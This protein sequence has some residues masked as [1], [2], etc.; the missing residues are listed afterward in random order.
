MQL[1]TSLLLLLTLLIFG[2][3]QLPLQKRFL[4]KED[5][6]FVESPDVVKSGPPRRSVCRDYLSY[7]PDTNHLDHS[8]IRYVRVNVHFMNHTDSTQ[9]FR[10]KDVDDFAKKLLKAAQYDLTKDKKPWLP[11]SIDLPALPKQYRYVLTPLPGDPNDTGVYCHYDDDLYYFVSSGRNRN[12]YSM[13]V[14]DK[15][16]IQSDSVLNIFIMP[17]HPDSMKSEKYRPVGGGIALRNNL[18]LAG[19]YESGNHSPWA[20]RG[21]LNH[22]IGHVLGLNH[23]WGHD[24][25]DDTPR[26]PNCWNRSEKP[27]CDTMASNNVMDY[28]AHQNAWTPCQIGK[29]HYNFARLKSRQRR[30]LIANWCVLKEENTIRIKEQIDWAGARDI[31]GHLIIEKGGVLQIRC[32]LSLPKGAKI[33]IRPGGKLILSNAH[34]HNSCGDEWEGIEIQSNKKGK[35]EVDL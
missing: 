21:L 20:F 17:H 22:E 29:I 5:I 23:A 35:G 16:A 27:P 3:C 26:H 1:K 7:V 30:M 33:I 11:P 19:V 14:I 15:Y 34:L 8:P 10:E 25:C 12:N 28:N 18:K 4:T 13:D 2:T 9:N 31:E 24:G 32:R 6:S